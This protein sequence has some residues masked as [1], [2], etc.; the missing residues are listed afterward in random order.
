MLDRPKPDVCPQTHKLMM[1]SH[2]MVIG[3][4]PIMRKLIMKMYKI[5][6]SATLN[7]K[8]LPRKRG[9][10]AKILKMRCLLARKGNFTFPFIPVN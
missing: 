1:G 7:S 8:P 3:Y 10:P 5:E 9:K 6:K 2:F 4:L